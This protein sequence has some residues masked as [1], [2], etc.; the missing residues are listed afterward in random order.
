MR[1]KLILSIAPRPAHVKSGLVYGAKPLEEASYLANMH[2]V[3][4]SPSEYVT[5]CI[6]VMPAKALISFH[7]TAYFLH[8]KLHR[9]DNTQ[10][11]TQLSTTMV[12]STL[13]EQDANTVTNGQVIRGFTAAVL[14]SAA[15]RVAGPSI[16]KFPIQRR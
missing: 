1:K 7:R 5:S 12:S 11:I 9:R 16:L 13:N 2:H 8:E 15:A 4:Y 3:T 10:M 14:V 6:M